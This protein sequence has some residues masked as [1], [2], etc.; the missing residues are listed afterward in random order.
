MISTPTNIALEHEAA[1]QAQISYNWS[2]AHLGGFSAGIRYFRQLQHTTTAYAGDTPVNQ[3]CCANNDEFFN[4]TTADVTWKLG[5]STTSRHGIRNSPTWN[6][7]GSKRDLGP[8]MV[9]NGSERIDVPHGM[10]VELIVNNIFD[11]YP[12]V[13]PTNNSYPYYDTGEYNDYGRAFWVEF[14]VRFGGSARP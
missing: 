12:P 14:G 6:A 10:Y 7:L 9:V 13:D 11:R 2:T 1:I 4:T 8:Y 3:L 5:P